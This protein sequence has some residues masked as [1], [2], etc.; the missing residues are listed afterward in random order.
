M[1]QPALDK[2]VQAAL[3]RD[4]EADALTRLHRVIPRHWGDENE[5]GQFLTIMRAIDNLFQR[6]HPR[7]RSS[8]RVS[9]SVPSIPPWLR[10]TAEGRT[11]A[12]CY[13]E[14]GGYRLIP[15]GPLIR[16]A[17]NDMA[18]SADTMADRFLGLA[19]VPGSFEQQGRAIELVHTVI[20]SDRLQGIA[21]GTELG[22]E[23]IVHIPMAIEPGDLAASVRTRPDT[24]LFEFDLASATADGTRSTAE[25]TAQKFLA[26][27]ASAPGADI[28]LA[29]EFVMSSI[30]AAAVS[31]GLAR[32]PLYQHRL[33]ASGSG[34]SVERRGG[35]A[36]NEMHV[37][38]H[39]GQP[40]WVQRKLWQ[41][42]VA[43]SVAACLG[44][45]LPDGVKGMEDIRSGNQLCVVDVDTLG[46]FIVLICQDLKLFE[47]PA[48]L[49]HLQCDWVLVPVL[50]TGAH[51]GRWTHKAPFGLS[52]D[53]QARFLVG[54]SMS[55]VHLQGKAADTPC[56]LAV[57]PR[58]PADRADIE[59]A[60]AT[61]SLKHPEQF[62]TLQWRR[63]DWQMT[64]LG[65]APVVDAF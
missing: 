36:W 10:T 51:E 57:G 64:T 26:I 41:A 54:S 53:S 20:S 61:R 32:T 44:H 46:R 59:R 49:N 34:I 6:V 39:M 38:N 5:Q 43:A 21:A 33:I 30:A 29:P 13:G 4:D 7:L 50:D 45:T 31:E 15:R 16:V 65:A 11:H 2:Y 22:A 27:A 47:L 8:P 28:V 14:E 3:E 19:V 56:L 58:V 37:F 60:F 17:R 25:D 9:P 55:L 1:D 42:E 40:L 35:V 62:V 63:G 24:H 48:V 52:E 12:G 18:A 23:R